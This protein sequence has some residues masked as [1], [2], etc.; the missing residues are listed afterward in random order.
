MTQTLGCRR[1]ESQR[2]VYGSTRQGPNVSGLA[3]GS[4]NRQKK[5]AL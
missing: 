5:L 4:S 2:T 1:P 3:I